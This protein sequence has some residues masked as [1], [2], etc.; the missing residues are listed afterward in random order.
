[1]RSMVEGRR[2]Q[3]AVFHGGPSTIRFAAGPPP[4]AGEDLLV[5]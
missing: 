4:R 3:T 5:T 1:M 2:S